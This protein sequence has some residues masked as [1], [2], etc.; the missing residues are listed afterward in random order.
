MVSHRS[1]LQLTVDKGLLPH[2]VIP[3]PRARIQQRWR[4]S[5]RRSSAVGFFCHGRSD[6]LGYCT[7]ALLHQS[8]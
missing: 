8:F 3:P 5:R 1:D 6:P 4:E 7:I 2:D